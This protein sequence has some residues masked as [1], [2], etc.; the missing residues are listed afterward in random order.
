MMFLYIN[1]FS[2]LLE[3][4]VTVTIGPSRNFHLKNQIITSC[5]L[6]YFHFF[7]GTFFHIFVTVTICQCR[8][9]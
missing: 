2:E 5:G 3:L 8:V 6:G 1:T 7:F 4:F 9:F